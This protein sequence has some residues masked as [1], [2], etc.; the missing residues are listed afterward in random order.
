MAVV[1]RVWPASILSDGGTEIKVDGSGFTGASKVYFRD[2]NGNEYPLKSF[3]VVNDGLIT[4]VTPNVNGV[5]ARD[6]F[7]VVNGKDSTRESMTVSK[8]DGSGGITPTTIEDYAHRVRAVKSLK[9][10][11]MPFHGRG[12]TVGGGSKNSTGGGFSSSSSKQS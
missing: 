1:A 12:G 7:V 2:P 9:R 10:A 11:T 8:N 6:L 3:T 5:G 4:G